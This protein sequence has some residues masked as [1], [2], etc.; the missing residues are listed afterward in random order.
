MNLTNLNRYS[1]Q[2]F[3]MGYPAQK[4]PVVS[5]HPREKKVFIV[6]RFFFSVLLY[7]FSFYCGFPVYFCSFSSHATSS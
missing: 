1:M 3:A 5:S 2:G 6:G 4:N 7:L